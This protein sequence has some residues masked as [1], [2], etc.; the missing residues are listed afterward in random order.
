[1]IIVNLGGIANFSTVV[2]RT[3]L[4]SDIGP[5]NCLS[6]DLCNYFFKKKFDNDGNYARKGNIDN[7]LIEKFK[8]DKFK[9]YLIFKIFN[10]LQL[11][12]LFG[13]SLKS[14]GRILAQY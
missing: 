12:L 13:K 10:F 5:A 11:A 3:L 2:S 8:K 9:N 14:W 7:E 4:S 1:V 6:D